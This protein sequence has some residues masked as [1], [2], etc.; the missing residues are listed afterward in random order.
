MGKYQVPVSLLKY[1]IKSEMLYATSHIHERIPKHSLLPPLLLLQSLKTTC[2]ANVVACAC[3]L[4]TWESKWG[5]TIIMS[6]RLIWI[7]SEAQAG[8]RYRTIHCLSPLDH[9]PPTLKILFATMIF[10]FYYKPFNSYIILLNHNNLQGNF[11]Y[12]I[13]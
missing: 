12:M 6:W 1:H 2:E 5:K 3:N 10:F 8:L 7:R 11:L 13:S 4:I 9:S